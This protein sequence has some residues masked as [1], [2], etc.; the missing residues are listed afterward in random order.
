MNVAPIAGNNAGA[1][2]QHHR[3]NSNPIETLLDRIDGAKK[4]GP[5]KWQAR[6]PA[7]DDRSPSLSIKAESDGKVLIK[8]WAGCSAQAIVEAVGLKLSDLFP[9]SSDYAPSK[10]PRYNARD[11]VQTL[12]LEATILVIGYRTLQHGGDLPEEDEA[13]IEVAIKAIGECRK[14]AR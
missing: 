12:M 13:R 1:T 6:C 7:H 8:C 5:D 14:V 9:R 3:I 10:P 2:S 11:V 4:T